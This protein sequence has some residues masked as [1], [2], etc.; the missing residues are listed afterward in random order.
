MESTKSIGDQGEN[1]ARDYLRQHGFD[2]VAANYRF[3]RKEI[4]L[5]ATGEGFLV[6]IEV[7]L[8]RSRGYG[9]PAEAVDARKRAAIALCARAFVHERRCGTL[10]CRFDVVSIQFGAD[11]VPEIEHIR[12]AFVD[13]GPSRGRR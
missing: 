5:V 8:R 3:R 11:G 7:K 4:D 1:L 10:P 9:S 13:G 2:I 6:F 12:N